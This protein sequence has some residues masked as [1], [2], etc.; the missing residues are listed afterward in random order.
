MIHVSK[1]D[2]NEYEIGR[3]QDYINHN[4]TYDIN[5][6]MGYEDFEKQEMIIEIGWYFGDYD[7]D[8]TEDYIREYLNNGKQTVGGDIVRDDLKESKNMEERKMFNEVEY[9]GQ[10]KGFTETDYYYEKDLGYDLIE[11]GTDKSD[12]VYAK[13]FI[14]NEYSTTE[15]L[16]GL[17]D[18]I[19]LLERY[20]NIYKE[21]VETR[22]TLYIFYEEVLK[23]AYPNLK[24]DTFIVENNTY[25]CG[26][27]KEKRHFT[28]CPVVYMEDGIKE[29]FSIEGNSLS[30]TIENIM[31]HIARI[32]DE[33]RSL[34][35]CWENA[36]KADNLKYLEKE[37]DK[38]KKL[39]DELDEMDINDDNLE[40]ITDKMY[41]LIY[42]VQKMW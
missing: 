16:D 3:V 37:I 31:I 13:L 11:Y 24:F 6:I 41:E 14:S 32:Y 10:M 12:G 35:Y 2:G 28:M 39:A 33:N 7:F 9:A 40:E 21:V 29:V 26:R 34:A 8:V 20:K 42:K 27:N 25:E 17:E 30:A 18:T 19:K 5:F 4:I 15:I 36:S 38:V 22:E 1:I 23:K